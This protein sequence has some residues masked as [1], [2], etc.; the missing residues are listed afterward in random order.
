MK[1]LCR[2]SIRTYR[3]IMVDRDGDPTQNYPARIIRYKK[4]DGCGFTYKTIEAAFPIQ[5][6]Y[7]WIGKQRS[8]MPVF[9]E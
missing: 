6:Y 7:T 4:C 5:D 1:C 9:K 3:T 8:I 2:G